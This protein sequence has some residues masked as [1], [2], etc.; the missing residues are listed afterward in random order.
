MLRKLSF[1]LGRKVGRYPAI[2]VFGGFMFLAFCL[3][4]FVN[5]QITD[6]PQE[7]WVPAKS[8]ANIEQQYFI[9]KFGPFFRI[10]TLWLTP[11][12]GEDA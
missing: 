3:C 5:M 4:G 9:D 10:N 12:P 11:G 6:D 8:R 7:L 2:F 1:W